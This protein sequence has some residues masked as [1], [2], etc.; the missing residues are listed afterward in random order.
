MGSHTEAEEIFKGLAEAVI[1]FDEDK[2]VEFA[3]AALE[4]GVDPTDAILKGLSRGMER[5]GE[6]YEQQEYFIPEMLAC[7]D[8]LNAAIE[9]LKPHIRAKSQGQRIKVVIGTVE[10]DIH[11]IGK[12]LVRIM[13]DAAGWEVYDLGADVKIER[14]REE[15]QKTGADVVAISALMTTS[16]LAIPEVIKQIK[17]Y[18]PHI[19]VM[20]GGAPLTLETARKYGA[21]GY[22]DNCGSAVKDT[23][24]AMRRVREGA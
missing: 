19:T 7:A 16:M 21:D 24:E 23:L 6:L 8:A 15:Q 14:F 13:Y 11:E 3:R 5:V 2:S 9:I 10:G 12:N 4:K 20:V 22:S 1:A 18:E 17:P